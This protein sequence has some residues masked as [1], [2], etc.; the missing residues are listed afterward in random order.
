MP[1]NPPQDALGDRVSKFFFHIHGSYSWFVVFLKMF[2]RFILFSV[3][4]TLR[5]DTMR[6]LLVYVV[7]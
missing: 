4:V 7:Q 6:S 3:P 1:Q 5:L 2:L